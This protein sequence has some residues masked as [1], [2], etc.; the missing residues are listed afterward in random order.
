MLKVLIVDDE[1]LVRAGI[2]SLLEWENN[3]YTVIGEASDGLEALDIM[4]K[5]CP[6]IVLM[7]IAMPN[8]GGIETLQIAKQ[9]YPYMHF[10]IL[11]CHNDF[12]YVRKAMK[13]GADDYILKLSM[14]PE[15]LLEILNETKEKIKLNTF[16]S[17]LAF[18][19][20]SNDRR[21]VANY[22]RCLLFNPEAVE[23]LPPAMEEEKLKL[24]SNKSVVA[25]VQLEKTPDGLVYPALQEVVLKKLSSE[26]LKDVGIAYIIKISDF[27]LAVAISI[28][29]DNISNP[30]DLIGVFAENIADTNIYVGISNIAE[31]IGGIRTAYAQAVEAL[32][33]KFYENKNIFV[34]SRDYF[35]PMIVDL[36]PMSMERDLMNFIELCDLT[37]ITNII[38]SLFN[39]IRDSKFQPS[40][41]LQFLI[42]VLQCFKTAIIN[43]GVDTP[44]YLGGSTH[45]IYTTVMQLK[46]LDEAERWFLDFSERFINNLKELKRNTYRSDI[47]KLMSYIR[48]HYSEDLTLK[49]AA[50]YVNISESYL[51]HLFKEQTGQNFTDFIIGLRMKKAVELL[52]STDLNMYDISMHIGYDNINYFGRLF[53]KVTGISPVNYRKKYRAN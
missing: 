18:S 36:F 41:N 14:L 1:L 50:C 9:R 32:Q 31:D 40:Q 48:E 46:C 17:G 16:G 23:Q 7:D 22:L 24:M 45:S 42:S 10:I 6:D 37:G 34:F 29:F 49:W 11:S 12:E 38:K 28:Q 30:N 15:R 44:D 3:G 20:G 53:K 8:M 26:R 2:K 43:L 52:K 51:S 4:E 21:L 19:D 35:N 47:L 13:L 39:R 27:E 25:L 5:F 33:Y